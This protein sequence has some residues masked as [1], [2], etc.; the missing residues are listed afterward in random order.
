MSMVAPKFRIND[1][2]H[3]YRFGKRMKLE[4]KKRKNE[5]YLLHTNRSLAIIRLA[6]NTYM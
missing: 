4:L 3:H 5:K 1:G 6:K 2:S